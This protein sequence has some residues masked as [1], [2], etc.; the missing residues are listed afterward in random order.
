[1][2]KW[3]ELAEKQPPKEGKYLV[4]DGN[5]PDIAIYQLF[6][7]T[8]YQWYPSDKSPLFGE[9]ITHW[10][11][12]NLPGES[13][14]T[15]SILNSIPVE[16]WSSEGDTIEYI[17]IIYDAENIGKLLSIGVTSSEI[18]ENADESGSIIDISPFVFKY[19]VANGFDEEGF[20]L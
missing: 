11:F 3:I 4:S 20:H 16:I 12:I 6:N 15:I 2:I 10:A 13:V 9:Q 17:N 14:D 8:E 19:T 7:A 5:E 1:M 18:D